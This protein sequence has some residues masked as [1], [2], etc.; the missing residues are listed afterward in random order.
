MM[1]DDAMHSN[2]SPNEQGMMFTTHETQP[3]Q[4]KCSFI[5]CKALE[6]MSWVAQTLSKV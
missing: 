4:R 6:Y 1:Y 2:M 3:I 5:V